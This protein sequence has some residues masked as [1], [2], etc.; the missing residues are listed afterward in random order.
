[1]LECRTLHEESE[2]KGWTKHW[3]QHQ[4]PVSPILPKQV[5]VGVRGGGGSQ[6]EVQ[7]TEHGGSVIVQYTI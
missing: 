5:G 4:M 7:G 3:T 1:M 6:G 2:W